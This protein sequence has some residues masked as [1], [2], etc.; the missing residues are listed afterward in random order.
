MSEPIPKPTQKQLDVARLYKAAIDIVALPQIYSDD[1]I[2][3]VREMLQEEI[4]R[5]Y[6]DVD[7]PSMADH[8]VIRTL[9]IIKGFLAT[10]K[11]FWTSKK[12]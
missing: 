3:T 4:D 2:D 8:D 1:V 10:Q 9:G 5:Q 11:S 7:V 6:R 12:S